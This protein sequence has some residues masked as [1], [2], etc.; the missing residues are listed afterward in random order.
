VKLFF[1]LTFV[2]VPFFAVAK[3]VDFNR[4]VR[5]ILS[6]NCYVC[7]GP[8]KEHRKAK[9][10]LDT[11]EGFKKVFLKTNPTDSEIIHRI[12]SH[13]PDEIMPTPESGKSLSSEEIKILTQ[14]VKEG[15]EYSQPWAYT[16]P[17]WNQ[18]KN[19]GN[20]WV[21]NWIDSILLDHWSKIGMTPSSDSNKV[22]LIRRLSF[23][24]T[25]LPPKP[26]IIK[27]YLS[28][29]NPEAVYL[30]IVQEF[31]DSDHYGERMSM[32]WLDLVRFADTVGYH[33]D[34]DHNISP[35][36]DYIMEAFNQNM[37]FDQFTRE[38]L[39]GD[40]LDSP[41]IDQKVATGYNRLLQTSH[42]GGVQP[43][44]YLA[45]YAAD[46]I[47]N[48]SGVWMGATVGC[49]QCHDHKY[50]PYTARDFY[51]MSAFFADID[52]EQ[53]FKVG[54]NALPTKRPPEIPVLSFRD[55]E[56]LKRLES[57][58]S[59]TQE[60]I[61]EIKSIKGR[62]RLTMVT[63]S[64]KP[65]VTRI[66]PRGNWL[67]DT[68]EI[69]QPAV[70]AFLG[71][72]KVEDRRAN[73]LDFA[74]WLVDPE[75]GVGG[76]TARVFVNRLWYLMFGEG[77][78]TSLD[79]FGGQGS[80]PTIPALL[81]NLSVEFYK[82]GWD[83]K[84]LIKLIVTSHAYKLSS[85]SD[86]KTKSVDPLNYH[87][88]HQSMHR[89]P[90]EMIRDN[91]L[92]TS[93]LL[94]KEYGGPS[95]KP[96]QPKGYYKHL[97][98]PKREYQAHTDQRRLKRSV[99]IHWQ[100]QF[101][102]PMLQ[103]MDAPTREECVAKRSKSNSPVAAMVLLNDPSF[104]E[105]AEEF[106]KIIIQSANSDDERI[107]FAFQRALSRDPDELEENIINQLLKNIRQG[108]SNDGQLDLLCWTAVTRAIFNF[109][110]FNTR[111]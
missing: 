37:P 60:I 80:P 14:W 61:N 81:D 62:E 41:S 93:G 46:R 87:F 109:S 53:H 17:V 111:N 89:L 74:N 91:I 36:R 102:H 96:F 79:D 5:P 66:L 106:A 19:E 88:S 3:E 21:H 70:P 104:Y 18:V 59:Q 71:D 110:E 6:Q 50:D 82:N 52:E 1:P 63:Q 84:G 56:K 99:Y 45:I 4:D 105:A 55:R 108:L 12:T 97:N 32:Y 7:H 16:K 107:K 25:G 42:E 30:D 100:R 22:T 20:P 9:L 78:S 31:L 35:Y 39:A 34:Q 58:K 83:I 72:L 49:A 26:E 13:D 94:F 77:I 29:T 73:R 43:R 2:L 69:V 33:G 51:S 64:I 90:A 44:E 98:F 8:D 57:M 11:E 75:N 85:N 76:L 27:K 65:R 47:R 23:D 67:D 68:G 86:S 28:A 10:R 92:E 38:Q 103:A 24:L 95:V 40:L 48:V 54:S 101:L 15:G